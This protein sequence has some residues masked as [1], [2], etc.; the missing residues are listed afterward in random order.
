[1]RRKQVLALVV[2]LTFLMPFVSFAG[3]LSEADKLDKI[4]KKINERQSKN[5]KNFEKKARAYFFEAQKPET[6]ETSIKEFTPGEA[7]AVIVISN[8]S[9]KPYKEV[10][11]MKKAGK[12]WP[13][14]A[15]KSG[16]KLKAVVKEEKDFRL[17]IG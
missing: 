6:I 12:G 1:M 2:L 8:L 13:E 10:A 4:I 5:L 11:S 9:K 7:V 14:I 3:K 16:A 15:E 17:G